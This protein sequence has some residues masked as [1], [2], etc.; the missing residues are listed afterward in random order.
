M[1]RD[2]AEG[3]PSRQRAGSIGQGNARLRH[4]SRNVGEEVGL[5]GGRRRSSSDPLRSWNQNQFY[6]SLG[7]PIPRRKPVSG[8]G[9]YMPD[10]AEE[11]GRPSISDALDRP[12][13][14]ALQR[15][16]LAVP[17]IEEDSASEGQ[18]SG[19]GFG[20]RLSAAGSMLRF[21]SF[22]PGSTASPPPEPPR[23]P[24]R[25]E[26]AEQQYQ[27]DMVDILDTVGMFSHHGKVRKRLTTC[28]QIQKFQHLIHLIMF[29][30]PFLSLI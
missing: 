8:Q 30:I 9:H 3:A 23:S 17:S 25:E 19:R 18:P 13:A 16:T 20:R 2:F 26:Q 12:D 7:V 24:T 14:A 27:D 11:T 6:D 5:G 15:S 21:P 4:E 28:K 1:S 22:R 29:R 10:V